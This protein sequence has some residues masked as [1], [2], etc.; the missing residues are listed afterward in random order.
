[1]AGDGKI[2]L[3]NVTGTLS[4]IQAGRDW[5]ILSTSDFEEDVYATP[6]IA[7]G[8]IYLRTSGHLYCFGVAAKKGGS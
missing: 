8:R 4:V 2:Y 7:D 1:V 3:V 5:K 6:A